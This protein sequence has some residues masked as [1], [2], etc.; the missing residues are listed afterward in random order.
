MNSRI[1]SMVMAVV[2]PVVALGLAVFQIWLIAGSWVHTVA[3]DWYWRPFALTMAVA[4]LVYVLVGVIIVARRPENR[5][6]PLLALIGI[7]VLLYQAVGEYALRGLVVVPGSLPGAGLAAIASQTIWILPFSLVPLL[8]LMYPTGRFL[9]PGWRLTVLLPVAGVLM[10]VVGGTVALWPQ[11]SAGEGLLFSDL[12]E[13]GPYALMALLLVALSLLT[14]LASVII[15]W[16]G[17]SGVERLQ[18]KWFV[19][20]GLIL[21]AQTWW[22]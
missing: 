9:S 12:P 11:R 1:G 18:M 4:A 3:N 20:A 13:I 21:V 16:R 10:I 2:A 14:G 15:R 8:L 6:G 7:S 19:P 5:V 22:Y 17:S